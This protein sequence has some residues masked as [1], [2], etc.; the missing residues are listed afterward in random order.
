[1]AKTTFGYSQKTLVLKA[2]ER[3]LTPEQYIE[4]VK[5]A[6]KA[7]KAKKPAQAPKKGRRGAVED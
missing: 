6:R 7:R 2:A 4:Q 3:N 1:M 5:A